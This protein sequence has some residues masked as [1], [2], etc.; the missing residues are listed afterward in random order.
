MDRVLQQAFR[1]H[2]FRFGLFFLL[3]LLQTDKQKYI[4]VY[5]VSFSWR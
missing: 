2:S 4:M 3:P 5:L 1:Q